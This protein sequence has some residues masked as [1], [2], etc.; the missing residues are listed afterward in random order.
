MNTMNHSVVK[1]FCLSL[2][3][4]FLGNSNTYAQDAKCAEFFRA[5]EYEKAVEEYAER[6]A[7]AAARREKVKE[8]ENSLLLDLDAQGDPLLRSVTPELDILTPAVVRDGLVRQTS[9]KIYSEMKA[10]QATAMDSSVVAENSGEE[11][12]ERGDSSPEADGSVS[13]AVTAAPAVAAD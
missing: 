1:L 9:Q 10:Q 5:M 4:L 13:P 12:Q 3:L 11:G 7:A 8:R 6:D 2:V